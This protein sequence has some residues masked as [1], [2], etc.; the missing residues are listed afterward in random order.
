M[1][2]LI[3][4]S[5]VV[6][7]KMLD[8]VCSC[9]H[10]V[11]EVLVLVVL[12]KSRGQS[13]AVW[14]PALV[15]KFSRY[16][17][18]ASMIKICRVHFTKEEELKLDK[19]GIKR[20]AQYELFVWE[21][22][23]VQS[24]TSCKCFF[25]KITFTLFFSYIPLKPENKNIQIFSIAEMLRRLHSLD[26][27]SRSLFL[28]HK[29]V[30][31]PLWRLSHILKSK[32]ILAEAAAASHFHFRV[33]VLMF[34]LIIRHLFKHFKLQQILQEIITPTVLILLLFR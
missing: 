32:S 1:F 19:G 26:L 21:I 13:E 3:T 15:K 14:L 34:C 17:N 18:M 33:C 23:H 7:L 4:V 10:S 20:K 28:N 24:Q 11:S 8:E 30:L 16:K 9:R 29:V 12:W 27:V 5:C 22:I 31:A 2:V 25:K 6:V